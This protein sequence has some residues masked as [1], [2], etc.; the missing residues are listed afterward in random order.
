MKKG[1]WV[2]DYL[3]KKGI[4]FKFLEHDVART[5]NDSAKLRELE[6]NQIAKALLYLLDSEPVLIVLSGDREVDNRKLKKELNVK[7][8]RLASPE[9][10][11]KYTDCVVG[12]VPPCIDGVKK[13]L[14]KKLLENKEVSFN[15]GTFNAGVIISSTD[16]KKILGDYSE[17]DISIPA[18]QMG[19]EIH[20]QLHTASKLFCGCTTTAEKPN[21]ATC[22]VC[23]GMP[24][25]KP[26]LNRKAVD[27]AIKLALALGCELNKEFFFSRKTYFY[28]DMAKNYQITQYESPVGK[29]GN[30]KLSNGKNIGITRVHLE[31]DPAALV[32]A[33][34]M[35]ASAYSLVDYNR[36][37]IPLVEIVTEPDFSSPKEAREFLDNLLNLINYLDIFEHGKDVLKVDSNVSIRGSERVEVK[38]ITGFKAVETAL[39]YEIKRQREVLEEGGKVIRETRGF[40]EPTGS[41]LSLRTKE[42]EDDYGY[43]SD[44]DLTK[45]EL[46]DKWIAAIK[47]QLPELPAEKAKRFQKEFNL[48]DYDAKV[49]SSDLLLSQIFEYAAKELDPSLAAKFLSRELLAILN[50]NNL[51]LRN[52]NLD[53]NE[54]IKL[55]K[56]LDGGKVS[57]K[58]A[59]EAMIKYCN[60]KITPE[61]FLKEEN[62]LID[63]KSADVEK[64]VKDVMD[65]NPKAVEELKQGKE[66]ALNFLIG[67][68]MRELK[69]KA[70][71]REI[72]KIIK[73]LI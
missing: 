68:A 4:K 62:L 59:K 65:K 69:G 41:T 49:I 35:S 44:P 50:Y 31:E 2:K 40:D 12:V 70:N 46:D 17:S 24:G 26:V 48:S 27:Y 22:E 58:N 10:V 33:E 42:T 55:L 53:S 47:K 60:E 36:S 43:I 45:I 25:S 54:I 57:E 9:E 7:K 13:V 71:A 63:L 29:N 37:G 21:S 39:A 38:N 15:A 32:H 30:L 6:L 67:S 28:P 19:I 56:L 14:D 1:N 16:L 64:A 61:K 34:G 3:E 8:I 72:E 5:C 51:N 73:G 66:K 11:E 20:A 23:L 52:L 18:A